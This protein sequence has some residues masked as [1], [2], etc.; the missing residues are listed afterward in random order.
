M[1]YLIIVIYVSVAQLDRATDLRIRQSFKLIRRLLVRV[2]SEILEDIAMIY[3]V[4][5]WMTGHEWRYYYTAS[6]SYRRRCCWCDA[7]EKL[8]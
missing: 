6:G 4:V 2:Q 5:C 1:R 3:Q 7:D 8:E